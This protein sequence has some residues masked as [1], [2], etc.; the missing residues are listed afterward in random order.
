MPEETRSVTQHVLGSWIDI[1]QPPS[2]FCS[3]RCRKDVPY[4]MLE[5]GKSLELD[6]NFTP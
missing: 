3:A 4:W 6:V 2:I 5:E 1:N